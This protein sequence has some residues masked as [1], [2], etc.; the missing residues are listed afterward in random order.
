VGNNK[1]LWPKTHLILRLNPQFKEETKIGT[2]FIKLNNEKCSKRK[3][4]SLVDI[5]QI[6]SLI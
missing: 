5:K 2:K 6:L 3:E 1:T 4:F